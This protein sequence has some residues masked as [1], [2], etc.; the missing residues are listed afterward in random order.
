MGVA[1]NAPTEKNPWLK[2][3]LWVDASNFLKLGRFC[4]GDFL[5]N[6]N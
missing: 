5:L 4:F 3:N 1:G 6:W 2:E